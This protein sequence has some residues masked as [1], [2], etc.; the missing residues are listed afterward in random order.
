MI[1]FEAPSDGEKDSD[2]NE[3]TTPV[4]FEI[5]LAKYRNELDKIVHVEEYRCPKPQDGPFMKRIREIFDASRGPDIGT[6]G[7]TVLSTAFEEQSEKWEP[8]TLSHISQTIVVVH[9]YILQLLRHLV[10]EEEILEELWVGFLADKIKELYHKA[11]EHARFLLTIERGRPMTFNSYFSEGLQERRS[12]R[13]ASSVE[14]TPQAWR[15]GRADSKRQHHIHT[16][17]E[18]GSQ[19]NEQQMC[20]DILD[21]FMS[22]YRVACKRFVDVVFQQA[23]SHFL[24]NGDDSPLKA[25]GP[26]MVMELTGDQLKQIAGEDEE[27]IHR[28]ALLSKEIENLQAALKVLRG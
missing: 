13:R 24:L 15:H 12:K 20:E 6:F 7:G 3:I 5:P 10:S 21:T 19:K 28:R 1:S 27:S 4:P 25:F 17:D 9:D 23:I 22:Y 26:D 14:E 8:L 16:T 2:T 11:M 18:Q